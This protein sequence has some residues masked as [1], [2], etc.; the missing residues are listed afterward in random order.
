VLVALLLGMRVSEITS[1]RVS[2]LD[3]DETPGDLLWIPCS[4]TPAGRRTLEV[5]HVLRPLLVRCATDKP[6]DTYR[7]RDARLARDID[8][9]ARARRSSDRGDAGHE[10]ERTTMAASAARSAAVVGSSRRVLVLLEG[11]LKA[12]PTSEK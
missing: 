3:E 9:R 5:P 4:M 2:E 8:R 11:G 1:C 10:D 12:S 7:A 6:S